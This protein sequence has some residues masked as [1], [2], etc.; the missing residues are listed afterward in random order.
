MC[1]G[2][3]VFP[4]KMESQRFVSASDMRVSACGD[5]ELSRGTAVSRLWR[6]VDQE[7]RSQAGLRN[8]G[9]RD[10]WGSAAQCLF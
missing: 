9:T 1:R 10:L 6:R 5:R 2:G 3:F 8:A 7:G 4:V